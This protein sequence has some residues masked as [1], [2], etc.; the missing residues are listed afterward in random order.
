MFIWVSREASAK[1]FRP[2]PGFC[3]VGVTTGGDG[4]KVREGSSQGKALFVNLCSHV[5]VQAPDLKGRQPLEALNSAE[6]LEIPLL[7]G[8][9]RHIKIREQDSI[10]V[11]A[12]FHPSVLAQCSISNVF[13]SQITD[14]VS[15]WIK[16]E[17]KILFDRLLR[18]EKSSL[19]MGGIGENGSTPVLFHVPSDAQDKKVKQ[20][21]TADD[22]LS[23]P[24]NLLQRKHDENESDIK[25]LSKRSDKAAEVQFSKSHDAVKSGKKSTGSIQE[26]KG[27]PEIN[28][29]TGSSIKKGFLNDIA[30][31]LYP[32]GSGEGGEKEEREGSTSLS[33][34]LEKCTVVNADSVIIFYLKISFIF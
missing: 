23:N 22:F 12:L 29:S 2:N 16:E 34:L 26:M 5:A 19:Y 30:T 32:E 8:D 27:M 15:Q 25:L 13:K 14:L 4:I 24:L 7:L 21:K 33:R 18:E 3:M 10:C 28:K 20:K 11:D 17:K 1:A 31:P 6:G 9:P